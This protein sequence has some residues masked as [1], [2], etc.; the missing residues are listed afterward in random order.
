M[1]SRIAREMCIGISVC[2][3]SMTYGTMRSRYKCP[4]NEDQKWNH[5]LDQ[6]PISRAIKIAVRVFPRLRQTNATT[7]LARGLGVSPPPKHAYSLFKKNGY[8]NTNEGGINR[9]VPTARRRA[10][11]QCLSP[12]VPLNHFHSA[13]STLVVQIAWYISAPYHNSSYQKLQELV[14]VLASIGADT[15]CVQ[16]MR[17]HGTT[18]VGKGEP[19]YNCHYNLTNVLRAGRHHACLSP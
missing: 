10:H 12:V 16:N 6:P 4:P 11:T 8:S 7:G 13:G 2:T 17:P 3:N 18:D 5:T 14:H 19:K 15:R 9:H 1:H